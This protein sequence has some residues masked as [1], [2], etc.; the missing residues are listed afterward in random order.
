ME[1]DVF[2]SY[3]RR[4]YVDENKQKL[5]NNIISQIREL[6]DNNDISY[7][8][9]EEG[10]FSGDAF[11][12]VIARNIKNAKTFLFV[13]SENSN[14]S[15]WTSNEIATAHAYKKRIIP[16]RY[17]DSVY[18]DSVIIYIARLDYIDYKGNPSKALTRLLTSVQNYLKE[19]TR[20]KEREY[21]EAEL[22]RRDEESRQERNSKLQGLLERIS[23]LENRRYQIDQDILTHDRALIDLRNE[24][25]IIETN[26]ANLHAEEKALVRQIRNG[27][28]GNDYEQPKRQNLLSREWAELK[29]ALSLKNWVVNSV[30]FIYITALIICIIA[31]NGSLAYAEISLLFALYRLL[32]NNRDGIVWGITSTI[33]C[34]FIINNVFFLI[35]SVCATL[36]LALMLYIKKDKVSAWNLLHPRTKRFK[37]DM[38]FIAYIIMLFIAMVL[39]MSAL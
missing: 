20:Q 8:F 12:P 6:F 38:L 35:L 34:N 29:T 28:D 7:W 32:K 25:R 31:A 15:E 10:V 23:S 3:S 1:Y 2:I 30:Y 11:A 36:F 24:K 27:Q 19:D 5:P 13:S 21:Q 22:R 26:L 37:K 17:D 9:D 14:A 4:D 33:L 18:N 16:F 39:Y